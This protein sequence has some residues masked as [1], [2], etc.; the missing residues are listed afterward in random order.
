[1]MMMR[2]RRIFVGCFLSLS[3][4]IQG[5]PIAHSDEIADKQAKKREE[6]EGS[7][8]GNVSEW[9]PVKVLAIRLVGAAAAEDVHWAHWQQLAR[10][11]TCPALNT[12]P[13]LHFTC[14]DWLT[15]PN[16]ICRRCLR[17]KTHNFYYIAHS[18]T[19]SSSSS[20]FFFGF[21]FFLL[22]SSS[23]SSS[24]LISHFN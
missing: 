17:H 7:A 12:C 6:R 15:L 21:Q 11:L 9:F 13:G 19:S 23:S 18:G 20:M 4:W 10:T 22:A 8:V 1:M 14:Q 5:L 2:M 16:N 3:S 24:S